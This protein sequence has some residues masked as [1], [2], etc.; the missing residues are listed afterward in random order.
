MNP[1]EQADTRAALFQALIANNGPD[2]NV[3]DMIAEVDAM[4]ANI[5]GTVATRR[6]KAR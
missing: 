3:K 4:M 6:P 2:R 1:K 5:T